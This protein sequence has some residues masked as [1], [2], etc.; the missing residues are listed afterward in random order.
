MNGYSNHVCRCDECREA[1]RVYHNEYRA[2]PEVRNRINARARLTSKTP[3]Q[4]LKKKAYQYGVEAELLG[5]YLEDGIC[6]ACGATPPEGLLV[7]HDHACCPNFRK[8]CGECVRGLLCRSC[9]YALGN[10]KDSRE[11]LQALIDYL[12]RWDRRRASRAA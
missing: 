1:Y 7:D 12:D 11:R 8:V 2:R 9:N 6:F 3:A 10:V 4:M 5:Q